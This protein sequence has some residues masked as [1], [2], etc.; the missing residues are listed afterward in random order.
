M[1]ATKYATGFVDIDLLEN[2]VLT[3][4]ISSI[5]GLDKPVLTLQLI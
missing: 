3:C 4:Y 5:N 1:T 2:D